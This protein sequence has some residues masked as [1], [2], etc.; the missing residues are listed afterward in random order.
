MSLKKNILIVGGTGFIGYHLAKHSLKKGWRVTSISTNPPKKIRYLS[1]VKYIRCD[2]ADKKLLK[3]NI[4][5]PF[6]YVVNL[7]GYVDHSNRKKT[8]KS[9][10]GG[11]KNLSEIFLKKMPLSFVQIG[12]SLE[13]GDS[14]SPQKENIKCSLKSI[15]SIYGRAKLLSSRYMIELFKKKKFPSTILRLY[16]VYGPRQD[17]N[18]FLPITIKGCLKNR[19]FPCSKGDQLRDFVHV[20]DAVEAMIK[21]LTN[22]KARGQIINIGSGKPRKIKNVIEKVKKISKGGYPQYGTFKVRKFEIPELYPNI[23][24]A[25]KKI[26]WRPKIE[27]EKGLKRTINSFK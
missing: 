25:K 23:A 6:D 22:K 24:K 1:K 21:A 26:N 7:G 19:K 12:S 14:N 10:Y 5:E 15:K 2:I 4:R 20:D 3:R 8:F 18:R 16:L 9:H 17:I 27:F 13:Y 11:C